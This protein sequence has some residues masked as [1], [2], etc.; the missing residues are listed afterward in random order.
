MSICNCLITA[1]KQEEENNAHGLGANL[2]NAV[3]GFTF[4]LDHTD[5]EIIHIMDMA[6]F[7]RRNSQLCVSDVTRGK[8]VQI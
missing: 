7:Y 6:D 2:L 5:D 4:Q 3:K 8:R 1:Q